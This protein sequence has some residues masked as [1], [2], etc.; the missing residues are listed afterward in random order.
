MSGSGSA[1]RFVGEMSSTISAN[2]VI[3]GGHSAVLGSPYYADQLPL[4]L[5]NQYHALPIAASAAT[6]ASTT[7]VHF[8]P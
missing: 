4:W 5:T 8:T 3:P 1:R 7:T 6:A 2:E